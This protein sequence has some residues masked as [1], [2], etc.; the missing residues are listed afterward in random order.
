MVFSCGYLD[1][2]IVPENGLK[3]VKLLGRGGKRP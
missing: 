1:V 2:A 3:M